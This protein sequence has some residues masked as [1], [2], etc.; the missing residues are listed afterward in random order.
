MAY[1]FTFGALFFVLLGIFIQSLRKIP[2]ANK[3]VV[4]FLGKRNGKVKD[5]GLRIFLFYPFLYGYILVDIT[6]KDKDLAPQ[7]VRTPDMA[8]IEISG[9]TTWYPDYGKNDETKKSS[10]MEYINTAGTGSIDSQTKKINDILEDIAEEAI[11]EFAI[12]E[13]REP[14]TWVAATKMKREFAAEVVM[15]M[16]GQTDAKELDKI[17]ND[18]RRGNGKLR[19]KSV[20]IVLSRVNITNVQPKGDLA[21]SAEKQAKEDSD[22][23]GDEVEIKNVKNLAKILI[24]E[25]KISPEQALEIVQTERGKVK[26]DISEKKFNLPP[27]I[28]A[29]AL[30]IIGNLT[31]G[32]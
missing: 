12:D 22:R 18:L 1:F 32:G 24:D 14:K 28:L 21:K 15:A 9:S 31:K 30:K 5:E 2:V 7:D 20:G 17:T 6:K 13:N 27:E 11:R 29:A 23:K 16:I 10:L 3:A 8:E 25:L 4:T 19:I 26:K